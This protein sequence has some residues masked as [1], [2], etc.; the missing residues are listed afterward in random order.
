MPRES[1]ATSVEYALIA[2]LISV[3]IVVS[4]VLLG[5]NLSGLFEGFNSQ[6][7]EC[8]TGGGC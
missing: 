3:V 4:V 2:G 6:Y 1:G 8:T 7:E 5:T